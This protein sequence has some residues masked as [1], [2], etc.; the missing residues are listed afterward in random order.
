MGLQEADFACEAVVERRCRKGSWAETPPLYK[1]EQ[2]R[3]LRCVLLFLF[4]TL[5]SYSFQ[6]RH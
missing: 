2:E 3:V 6:L 1:T 4:S 5:F